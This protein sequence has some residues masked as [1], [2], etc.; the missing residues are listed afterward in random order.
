MSSDPAAA[1][2]LV[3]DFKNILSDKELSIVQKRIDD[4]YRYVRDENGVIQKDSE[5][6]PIE[7]IFNGT[8]SPES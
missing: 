2:Q 7:N 6:N 1:V 5:G 3:E 8:I 4:N